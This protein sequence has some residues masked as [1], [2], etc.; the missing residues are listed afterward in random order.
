MYINKYWRGKE[1]KNEK[2]RKELFM[3]AAR[4]RALHGSHTESV[5]FSPEMIVN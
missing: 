2:K 1:E 3:R 4:T 5:H